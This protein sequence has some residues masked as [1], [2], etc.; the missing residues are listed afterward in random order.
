MIRTVLGNIDSSDQKILKDALADHDSWSHRALARAL[1]DRGLPLGEK[2]IRDRRTQP[3]AD[4]IC[5]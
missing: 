3:C 1:T 5:R 2:I 4:C